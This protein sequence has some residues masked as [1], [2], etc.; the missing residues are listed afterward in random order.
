MLQTA[1][2]AL[3]AQSR[4]SNERADAMES[5]TGDKEMALAQTRNALDETASKLVEAERVAKDAV[6]V[7][8]A[9]AES[10]ARAADKAASLEAALAEALERGGAKE[11][12]LLQTNER[13]SDD[14]ADITR[15]LETSAGRVAELEANV[16]ANLADAAVAAREKDASSGTIAALEALNEKLREEL[17]ELQSE[18][19][20]AGAPDTKKGKK[21]NPAKELAQARK[22]LKKASE[23]S[24]E[25]A[26][27][28]A[29]LEEEKR[30]LE[31]AASLAKQQTE[32]NWFINS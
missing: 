20:L 17:R 22:Q 24:A 21:S 7:V 31:S 8:E 32:L 13:L 3:Q 28:E 4:M 26:R 16:G 1:N 5:L 2:E 6:A 27:R 12:Q 19:D 23:A 30:E 15:R 14:L 29:R 9:A 25:H 11:K 10:E 18:Y